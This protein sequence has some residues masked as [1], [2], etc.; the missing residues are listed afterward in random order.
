MTL[1]HIGWDRALFHYW[2]D[3]LSDG[4][5]K[6]SRIRWVMLWGVSRYLERNQEDVDLAIMESTKKEKGRR[7]SVGYLLP[8]R[9]ELEVNTESSLKTSRMRNITRNIKKHALEYE[10]RKGVEDFNLFYHRMYTPFTAKRHGASANIADYKHFVAQFQNEPSSLFFVMINNEPVAAAYIEEKDEMSRLSAFGVLDARDDIYGKGVLGA[11]YYFFI[12][13]Y[14]EKGMDS[15]LVGNSM[16][17]VFDG[18]TETKLQIGA[19]PHRKDLSNKQKFYFIPLNSSLAINTILKYNPLYHLENDVVEIA[20]FVEDKD[21][22][23]KS[24][25]LQFFKRL[26]S[27]RVDQTTIFC[28]DHHQRIQ[29]WILEE[30]KKNV[31]VVDYSDSPHL[32]SR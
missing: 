18:V 19:A 27:D 23:E 30:D 32:F 12:Q 4:D 13:Y 8:R 5:K 21:Y 10:V 3:R 11:L 7:Y 25:F 31:K 2:L 16:P 6:L 17:V 22:Q 9:I 14:R 29:Q 15:L 1:V 20:V 28:L 24:D 26:Y